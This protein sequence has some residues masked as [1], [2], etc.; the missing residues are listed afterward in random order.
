MDQV[1]N[2][3]TM[4]KFGLSDDRMLQ[5]YTFQY[6]ISLRN[7]KIWTKILRYWPSKTLTFPF[8]VF[9]LSFLSS[10]SFL[11]DSSSSSFFSFFCFF[12]FVFVSLSSWAFLSEISE[13]EKYDRVVPLSL[14]SF[15]SHYGHWLLGTVQGCPELNTSS[16]LTPYFRVTVK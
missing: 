15:K 6:E 4:G 1:G 7:R 13:K 3:R 9:F 2:R 16:T 10:L 14:S 8:L 12:F 5:L 11:L